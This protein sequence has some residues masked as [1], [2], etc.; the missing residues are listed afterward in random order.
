MLFI[1]IN[2]L[3]IF[4]YIHPIRVCTVPI[5]KVYLSIYCIAMKTRSFYGKL[6]HHRYLQDTIYEVKNSASTA[7]VIVITGSLECGYGSDIED[8]EAEKLEKNI[9]S[10]RNC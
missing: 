6:T 1:N 9:P 7:V 5:L 8:F 10:T 4:F 2:L 3:S